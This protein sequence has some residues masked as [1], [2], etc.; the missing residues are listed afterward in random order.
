MTGSA[1]GVVRMWSLD[2]IEVP[3]QGYDEVDA[4]LRCGDDKAA[5]TATSEHSDS[6]ATLA[7]KMSMTGDCLNSFRDVVEKSK[8]SDEKSEPSSDT[9][10]CEDPDGQETDNDA[11]P[12]PRSQTPPPPPQQP[13]STSSV[14]SEDFVVVSMKEAQKK[15]SAFDRSSSRKDGY[16]WAKKLVFRARL[17]MHTAFERKDNKDPAAVT[18]LAVSKDHRIIYVGDDKGR[19]FSWTVSSKP[20]KGKERRL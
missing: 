15:D 10:E 3:E 4:A 13:Q 1:D 18:A 12:L 16:T 17:T 19:V 14:A 2:Y 7:K 20:G 6:I 9:E 11:D 5:D 8:V